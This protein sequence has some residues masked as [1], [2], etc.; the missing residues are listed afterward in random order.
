M[1]N[2]C[3]DDEFRALD[4]FETCI[5]ISFAIHI[6]NLDDEKDIRYQNND[7]VLGDKKT[8]ITGVRLF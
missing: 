3:D 8:V 1:E 5:P 4:S 2:N 6:P 7:N